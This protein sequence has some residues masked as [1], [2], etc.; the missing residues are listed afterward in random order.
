VVSAIREDTA[1]SVTVQVQGLEELPVAAERIAESLL[2]RRAFAKTQRVDNLLETETRL[3][4][5]KKGSVKFSVGVADL[6]SLGHGG[7]GAGFSLGLVYAT[8]ALALPVEM[9][10]GWDDASYDEPGIGLFSLSVGARR[11]LSKQ[12]TSPFFGGG[13]GILNLSA[14]DEGYDDHRF[15][16]SGYLE[17]GVEI[18]RLHRGRIGLQLRADLPFGALRGERY[19]DYGYPGDSAPAY[20]QHTESQYVV[21]VTIG[22]NVAF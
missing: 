17:A 12:D 14:R 13:L 8:P 15:G 20:V 16:A 7:R 1:E 6:E 21:P 22:L 5:T 2:R 11:Y 3:A 9:R 4:L 10:F 19:V 18:L